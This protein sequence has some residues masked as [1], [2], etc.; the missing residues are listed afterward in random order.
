MLPGP[1]ERWSRELLGRPFPAEPRSTCA[2]CAML[3]DAPDLPPEGPFRAEVRCC[4]YQ[5]HLA[6]HL[7][8]YRMVQTPPSWGVRL[9]KAS[10]A[11]DAVALIPESR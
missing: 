5:P 8:G 11:D 3:P 1:Y 2:S 9:L 4:T 7:V 6:P 10:T